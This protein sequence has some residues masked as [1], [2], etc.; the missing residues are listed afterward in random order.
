MSRPAKYAAPTGTYAII[1]IKKLKTKKL[2]SI[3][4]RRKS[5]YMWRTFVGD[6]DVGPL[7]PYTGQFTA[8]IQGFFSLY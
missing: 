4:K 6:E 8:Q 7:N 2:L 5:F 3:R 1:P